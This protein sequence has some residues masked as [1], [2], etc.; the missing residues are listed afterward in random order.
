MWTVTVTLMSA[1]EHVECDD[2]GGGRRRR[3][4]VGRRR[5]SDCGV[6]AASFLC[7]SGDEW[8]HVHL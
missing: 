1:G 7:D 6:V 2:D 8:R 3:V 5:R 4:F